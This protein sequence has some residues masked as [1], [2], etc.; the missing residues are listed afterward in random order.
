[1]GETTIKGRV[2]TSLPHES[3][4]L[5]VCG[6]AR[7]T[8]D[9]PEPRGT[10]HAAIGVSSRP[11]ARISSMSLDPV[12]EAPGVVAVITAEDVPGVRF[13]DSQAVAARDRL[14]QPV[15]T[16]SGEN[17]PARRFRLVGADREPPAG[18]LERPQ[19]LLRPWRFQ[20]RQIFRTLP[21]HLF[22]H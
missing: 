5:H 4:D 14:E 22:E 12:R 8:D 7:Y 3:A 18:R 16:Q 15:E 17:G 21:R 10:L 13:L 20:L 1:M 6:E 11:H 9:I 19:S 2:G